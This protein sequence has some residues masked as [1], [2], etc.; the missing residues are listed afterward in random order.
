M[1]ERTI[2]YQHNT[3]GAIVPRDIVLRAREPS[4]R[5]EAQFYGVL[6]PALLIGGTVML[7]RR[8]P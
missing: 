8:R 4:D 6:L 7:L 2:Y 3:S 5:G 1:G